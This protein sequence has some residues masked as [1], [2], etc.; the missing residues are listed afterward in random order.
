MQQFVRLCGDHQLALARL[1]LCGRDLV[2]RL[3]EQQKLPA[4]TKANVH[5]CHHTDCEAGVYIEECDAL[6]LRLRRFDSDGHRVVLVVIARVRGKQ[7]RVSA[8]NGAV[9]L[10]GCLDVLDDGGVQRRLSLVQLH[11]VIAA[12]AVD[13]H[14][15]SN[16]TAHSFSAAGFKFRIV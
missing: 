12:R 10:G 7:Q 4:I 5:T 8:H 16:R 15:T 14:T 2:Q 13:L 11:A 9:V 6:F 1:A 3:A